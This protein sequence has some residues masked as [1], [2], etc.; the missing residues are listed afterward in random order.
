MHRFYLP[1]PAQK[2][3]THPN[4]CETDRQF[5]C[6][7]LSVA[8][9]QLTIGPNKIWCS[10]N[11]QTGLMLQ[12]Q[13]NQP[14]GQ[15]QARIETHSCAEK[16]AC[17][18]QQENAWILNKTLAVVVFAH[19]FA[20]ASGSL[21]LVW[22]N[23]NRWCKTCPCHNKGHYRRNHS[24]WAANSSVITRRCCCCHCLSGCWL[25]VARIC[26]RI[27]SML[28][29]A[30]C[31]ITVLEQ[32]TTVHVTG[33]CFKFQSEARTIYILDTSFHT[34]SCGG[35]WGHPSPMNRGAIVRCILGTCVAECHVSKVHMESPVRVFHVNCK[36][37]GI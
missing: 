27:E 2:Q 21:I 5:I 4:C 14:C 13:L 9:L 11:V 28:R 1:T 16:N 12:S 18:N 15:Q 34:I 25:V 23:L 32:I 20:Q 29:W 35:N 30:Y 31:S 17:N 3:K 26:V 36:H 24:G 37:W 22:G 19:G 7:G 6:P 33:E 10:F 8:I